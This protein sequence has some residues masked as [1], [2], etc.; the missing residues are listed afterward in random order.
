MVFE[1]F[2]GLIIWG[3]FIGLSVYIIKKLTNFFLTQGYNI[4][5]VVSVFILTI[6]VIVSYFILVK[7]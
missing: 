5:Q 1:L 6:A 7:K 4:G 3:L 2:K